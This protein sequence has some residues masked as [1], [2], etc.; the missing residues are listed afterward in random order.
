MSFRGI[1]TD[2]AYVSIYIY[3]Y[4][5]KV[6]LYSLNVAYKI[7]SHENRPG[8]LCKISGSLTKQEVLIDID[9][10][11]SQHAGKFLSSSWDGKLD[12]VI[13]RSHDIG[14][15]PVGFLVFW[16]HA[17]WYVSAKSSPWELW[18]LPQHR[19]HTGIGCEKTQNWM[20]II[21]VIFH[22]SIWY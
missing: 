15:L 21:I 17:K 14:R 18:S 16:P 13:F 6:W 2:N 7:M 9:D 3:I 4:I 20:V 10:V 1:Y 11:L 8:A 5:Y 12:F 22:N 19:I